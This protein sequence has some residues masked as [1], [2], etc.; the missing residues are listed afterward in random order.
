M[1]V[2]P[3]RRSNE[4]HKKLEKAKVILRQLAGDNAEDAF[5]RVRL[6]QEQTGLGWLDVY[7][8]VTAEVRLAQKKEETK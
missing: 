2:S 4:Y 5:K 6:I 3:K 8:Q 7:R 1:T